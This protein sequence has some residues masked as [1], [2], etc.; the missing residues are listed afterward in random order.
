MGEPVFYSLYD[1]PDLPT[2]APHDP[3]HPQVDDMYRSFDRYKGFRSWS[4]P[5]ET[6]RKCVAAYYGLVTCMDAMIGEL[7]RALEEMGQLEDTLILYTSDHG[8]M[9]GERGCWHKSY[10]Y[11]AS[12]QVPLIVRS[13]ADF[14]RSA[15]LDGQYGL[16]LIEN[17]QRRQGLL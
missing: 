9:L 11:N 1:R 5:P 4:P 12:A 13:P 10:L 7:L 16:K 6:L 2:P 14:V 8:D 15:V 17:A 3:A